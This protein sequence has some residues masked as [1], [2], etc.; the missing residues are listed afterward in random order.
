MIIV[1]IK[2]IDL[3]LRKFSTNKIE[4]KE[5]NADLYSVFGL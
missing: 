4:G 3:T 1:W 2:V 5:F